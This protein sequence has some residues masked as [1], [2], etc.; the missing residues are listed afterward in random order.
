MVYRK[1]QHLQHLF[2]NLHTSESVAV[3]SSGCPSTSAQIRAPVSPRMGAA[4]RK[5]V[6]GVDPPANPLPALGLLVNTF[7]RMVLEGV[8]EVL[9]DA[10]ARELVAR[11]WALVR[12]LD[13]LP[14]PPRALDRAE[15]AHAAAVRLVTMIA[16]QPPPQP[17]RP[18][19]RRA[20]GGMTMVDHRRVGPSLRRTLD[21]AAE[22]RD[23]LNIAR[24]RSSARVAIARRATLLLHRL[25]EGLSS[26]MMRRHPVAYDLGL[27]Y[28]P[29]APLEP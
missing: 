17:A 5:G 24:P 3:Y 2:G 9:V 27:Y 7:P 16:G 22:L 11:S 1:P 21:V 25:R 4:R 19:Q 26:N 29:P 18:S 6:E 28:Q 23:R 14:N 10:L 15:V 20:A 13:A 12:L 8:G